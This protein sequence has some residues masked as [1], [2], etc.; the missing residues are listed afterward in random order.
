MQ[1]SNII[2][3][4]E[5]FFISLVDE[6]FSQRNI[7]PNP[8]AVNYLVNLLIHYMNTENLFDETSESGKKTRSTLAELYLKAMNSE[9]SLQLDLIRKLG[10]TSLYVSGFF[11]E[12][13]N[14]KVVDIEYYVNMGE[15]AFDF[16]SKN[17][18]EDAY[19]NLYKNFALQFV[20]YMDSL[21]YIAQKSSL[22][23]NNDLLKLYDNYKKTGSDLA[24]ETLIENGF[25]VDEDKKKSV[26]Q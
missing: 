10:N 22:H 3:Q 7:E 9:P 21:T 18:A 14:K 8:L 24:K 5:D 1:N 13:L 19:K 11:A 17:I 2:L 20:D 12:S 15:T 26:A 23:N 25:L 4:S 6:A 16:L